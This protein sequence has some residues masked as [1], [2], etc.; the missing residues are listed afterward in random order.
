MHNIHPNKARKRRLLRLC[1]GTALAMIIAAEAAIAAQPGATAQVQ[2]RRIRIEPSAIATGPLNPTGR[3]IDLT[4]PAKDGNI[5]L[6]DVLLRI[7]ADNS[8]EFSAQRI[9]DLLTNVLDPTALKALQGSFA[10]RGTVTAA[11]FEAS[12]VGVSYDP[13]T[14][15]LKLAI[16][17]ERRA[18]RSVMVSPMD[19]DRIGTFAKPAGFSAYV[20]VRGSLDYLHNG[21]NDGFGDPVFFLDGAT[22]IGGV[23]LESEAFYQPGSRNPDFQRQGSRM[24][25]DDTNNLL[26]WSAG[27]LQTVSRGFQS[28]PDIA[29]LSVFRSYSTLQPQ[30][31]VRPRGDR[32]FRLDRPST[33]EVQVNG[34]IVRRLQLNPGV[35][36]LR[37]FPF[38]QGANDIKL[39]I[40]DDTGRTELLRFNVFLDQSQLAKGLSEFGLYAGVDAPLGRRGPNYT[41]DFTMSG[42]FRHGLSDAATVG[43]NI[44]ADK[45]VEMAGVEGVFG[46]ALGTIS[47]NFSLSEIKDAGT[48]YASVTTFQRLIQRGDG[49]TDSLNLAFE[50]RSKNFGPAGTI[51]PNNPYKWEASGGYSHAFN[52]RLY[53]GVDAR[54]SRARGGPRDAQTYRA[55]M[56][57]RI[58]STASLTADTRYERDNFGS[59]VSGL[60]SLNVRLGRF[61]SARADYD[62]RNNR[63][64]LSLQTLQG[65]GVGSF[66]LSADVERSDNSAGTSVNANYFAN[67]A[68]LGFSHFGTYTDSFGR[69][70]AQRSAVRAA[71]SFAFA[72]GAFS[73][74]RPIYDSFAIVKGHRSLKGTNIA[75][76]PT[77]HGRTADTG[78]LNAATQP[79]LSSYSERTVSVDAPQA[80]GGFDLGQGAYRAFPPY[81]SGYVFTVGSEYSVTA[82][83]RLLNEDGE[84]ISLLTGRAT[85][86]AKP[87][88]PALT[89]FT[90]REGKF[91][92]TGLRPGKWR[93][94]MLDDRKSVF[95]ITIAD[96]AEGAVKIGDLTARKGQ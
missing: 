14:L 95:E 66:N 65:Q 30:Q 85:E 58:S 84:P 94:E 19:R 8:I 32:S 20:N 73:I 87:D 18:S 74:G 47:L 7:N 34:Q 43:F 55:T 37:D 40:Q 64:R 50:T 71:T 67:R 4:I 44:Q 56:G 88:Q 21:P 27:D 17:P 31:I 92:I 57:Y 52:D 78:M 81:K 29:G 68:E 76:E 69:S 16:A 72:D 22:R 60:L 61:T 6:G 59:R 10:G 54:Y 38:T 49:R 63:S 82:M 70:I 62:T 39:N 83:G 77:P 24:V 45:N 12:G 91:G 90:N 5:Y 46:T 51:T 93:I 35:Y 23:V 3:A 1:A 96:N 89:V 41:D 15:E 48:G 79:N 28:A 75:V 11:D 2:D 36:N 26:R 9:L 80:P 86:L 13:Q 33:V 53:G 42:F 25:I